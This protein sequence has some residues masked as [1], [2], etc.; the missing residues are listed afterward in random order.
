MPWLIF[1]S[2]SG[3]GQ[4]PSGDGSHAEDG[5]YIMIKEVIAPTPSMNS[6]CHHGFKVEINLDD[7]TVYCSRMVVVESAGKV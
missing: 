4:R 1:R 6:S 3:H 5:I 7:K 2:G